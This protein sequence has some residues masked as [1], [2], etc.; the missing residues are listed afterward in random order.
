MYEL[1]NFLLSAIRL[2]RS[3]I[4]NLYLRS[5]LTIQALCDLKTLMNSKPR[6]MN[7]EFM[8]SVLELI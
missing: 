4:Q 3:V 5:V 1:V 2:L 7:P 8:Y 6:N